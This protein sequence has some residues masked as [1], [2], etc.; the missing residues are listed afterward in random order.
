M[1]WSSQCVLEIET[2]KHFLLRSE[3]FR[4]EREVVANKCSNGGTGGRVSNRRY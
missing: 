4:E 1:E 2:E 3:G